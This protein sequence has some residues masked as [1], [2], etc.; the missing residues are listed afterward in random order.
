MVAAVSRPAATGSAVSAVAALTVVVPREFRVGVDRFRKGD[1]CLEKDQAKHKSRT[2][3]H[4][5]RW[6]GLLS[7]VGVTFNGV[8]KEAERRSMMIGWCDAI[9]SMWAFQEV[10][11]NNPGLN[12][13]LQRGVVN[14]LS[15]NQPLP[16]C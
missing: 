11:N 15:I 8:Q 16:Y 2:N 4:L 9:A 5:D 7:I 13:D 3:L 1:D 6:C 10:L 12:R 14:S